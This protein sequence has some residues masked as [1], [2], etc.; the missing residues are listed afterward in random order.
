MS[1]ESKHTKLTVSGLLDRLSKKELT[2]FVLQ[3]SKKERK[4]ATAL[5]IAFAYRMEDYD[6]VLVFKS[7]LNEIVPIKTGV[8]TKLSASQRKYFIDTALTFMDQIDDLLVEE[9]Y[10]HAFAL[11]SALFN[12]V[13]YLVNEW[14]DHGELLDISK[15]LH[16]KIALFFKPSVARALQDSV[17]EFLLEMAEK[18]YYTYIYD[19]YSIYLILNTLK[20]H[21]LR[22]RILSML[23]TKLQNAKTDESRSN[24]LGLYFIVHG[25]SSSLSTD[26]FREYP[27][28]ILQT[29]DFLV[30]LNYV[31]SGLGIL[32]EQFSSDT[33]NISVLHRLLY[34][35]LA[36]KSNLKARKTA[37]KVYKMTFNPLYLQIMEDELPEQQRL[38]FRD[39]VYKWVLSTEN[40][41]RV[42]DYYLFYDMYEH[43]FSYLLIKGN[44]DLL[45]KYDDK[46]AKHDQNRL[47]NL[48]IQLIEEYALDHDENQTKVRVKELFQHFKRKN[49]RDLASKISKN[50]SIT[51]RDK[52]F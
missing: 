32:E 26:T 28:T 14:D 5:K 36:T 30:K 34:A 17:V 21:S 31:K 9:N 8:D 35:Y 16:R 4:V 24:Y 42:V 7:L 51:S 49:Y 12:K 29:Y 11:F 40:D 13:E 43:A 2:T 41:L 50:L 22:E 10:I 27:L 38:R 19:E 20:H 52:D 15:K 18:S 48:Y 46:L 47:Q 25:N 3:Y 45:E 33:E 39:D 37:L 1:S 23:S 44:L 6:L